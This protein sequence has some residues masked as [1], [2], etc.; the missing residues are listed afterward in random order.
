MKHLNEKWKPIALVVF[1][2]VAT[3]GYSKIDTFGNAY[4]LFSPTD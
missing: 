2:M 3:Y 4:G 1:A